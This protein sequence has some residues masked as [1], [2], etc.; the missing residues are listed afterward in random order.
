MSK[1]KT[2]TFDA[3][4][5]LKDEADIAAYLQVAIEDGDPALLAAAVG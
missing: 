3:S 5:Y 4:N 2:R 1:N